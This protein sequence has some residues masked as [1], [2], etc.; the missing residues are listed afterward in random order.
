[1]LMMVELGR[2]SLFSLKLLEMALRKQE[3]YQP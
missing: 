2:A 3:S 1:M